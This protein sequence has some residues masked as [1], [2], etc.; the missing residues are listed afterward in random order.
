MWPVCRGRCRKLAKMDFFLVLVCV[1]Y[2][3]G[4]TLESTSKLVTQVPV[5]SE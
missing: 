1:G 2:T 4:L 3:A 5:V